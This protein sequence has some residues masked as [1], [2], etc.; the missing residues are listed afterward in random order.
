MN[1]KRTEGGLVRRQIPMFARRPHFSLYAAL[2]RQVEREIELFLR[3]F[4]AGGRAP[5]R[6]SARRPEIE[7]E[8]SP[9]INIASRNA[10]TRRRACQSKS[11]PGFIRV[12]ERFSMRRPAA[13]LGICL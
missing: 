7:K 1:E 5:E 13:G 12:S 2:I 11:P 10:N 8:Q 9:C 6:R 4:A 3:L